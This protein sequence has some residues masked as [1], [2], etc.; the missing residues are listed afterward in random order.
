MNDPTNKRAIRFQMAIFV[1]MK[2]SLENLYRQEA[3]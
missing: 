2:G 1:W 3:N